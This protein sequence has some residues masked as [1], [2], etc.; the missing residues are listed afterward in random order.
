MVHPE[1]RGQVAYN[2]IN[3]VN[4][5][6]ASESSRGNDVLHELSDG[7]FLKDVVSTGRLRCI[8]DGNNIYRIINLLPTS[9][10]VEHFLSESCTGFDLHFVY[11]FPAE[12]AS[13]LIQRWKEMDP[14][15]QPQKTF[16][17]MSMRNVNPYEFTEF[18]V[19]SADP[20]LRQKIDRIV[21]DVSHRGV[22]DEYAEIQTRIEYIEHPVYPSC[23]IY[24]VFLGRGET[25]RETGETIR[26]TKE[27]WFSKASC[28]LLIE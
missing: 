6:D 16:A 2:V 18:D 14:R 8:N 5:I 1:P 28:T 13:G 3:V 25:K 22:L 12:V 15:R 4:V 26:W 24:A 19:D 27:D 9:F 23:R 20:L 11:D 17:R 7:W 10:W 21:A